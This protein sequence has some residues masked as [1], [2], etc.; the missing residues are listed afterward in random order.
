MLCAYRRTRIPQ[1]KSLPGCDGDKWDHCRIR[2]IPRVL[3]F[4]PLLPKAH[5][6]LPVPPQTPQ[7]K[8][9]WKTHNPT[10][11]YCRTVYVHLFSFIHHCPVGGGVC[12]GGDYYFQGNQHSITAYVETLTVWL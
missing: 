12:V 5:T 8:A 1:P 10:H 11:R 2:A 9:S 4:L 7:G 6:L 3:R